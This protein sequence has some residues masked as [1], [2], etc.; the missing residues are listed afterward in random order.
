MAAGLGPAEAGPRAGLGGVKAGRVAPGLDPA[1]LRER[2]EA[3]GSAAGLVPA[4]ANLAPIFITTLWVVME[5]N[6]HFGEKG[7]PGGPAVK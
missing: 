2:G 7:P 3:G 5:E 6:F 1:L 4:G